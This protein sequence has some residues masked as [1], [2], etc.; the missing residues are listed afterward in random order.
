MKRHFK[1]CILYFTVSLLFISVMLA[2]LQNR[3]LSL[4]EIL[5]KNI[6]AGGGFDSISRIKNLSFQA[7]PWGPFAYFVSSNGDVK[8]TFGGEPVILEATTVSQVQVRRNDLNG[9]SDVSG[10]E[11]Y[12]LQ[13]LA[14][15]FCGLF[16]LIHFKDNLDYLGEKKYGSE[17]NHVLTTPF[18]DLKVTF[19][20]DTEAFVI[21]RVLF[22]GYEENQG[23]Y[24]YNID[25]G[26]YRL[27]DNVNLP[28]SMFGAQL[29]SQGVQLNISKVKT[30]ESIDEDFYSELDI[31]AGVPF[32][33][34]GIIHGNVLSYGKR[35]DLIHILTNWTKGF[36]QKA[37]LQT[38]DQL[39]LE[40]DGEEIEIGF[41]T[42]V[43]EAISMNAFGPG[44]NIMTS[45]LEIDM[46]YWI[47]FY[48]SKPG[49]G[50]RIKKKLGLL[51]PIKLRRRNR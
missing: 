28:S 26:P 14:R 12:R 22:E 47:R 10:F 35:S 45:N 8:I 13:C 39:I 25:F 18:G 24:V 43:E 33:S 16:T 6:E 15:L 41:Y 37:G 40:L 7:G 46:A 23:H 9:I 36:I 20:L 31:N 4:K 21:T 27:F 48:L 1:G 49:Q 51:V 38:E 29:G 2:S 50:D 32:I 42:S 44:S 3:T 30:N 34:K 11:K 5:E 17:R 19:H